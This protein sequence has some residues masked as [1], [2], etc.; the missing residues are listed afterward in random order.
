MSST[1][2]PRPGRVNPSILEP[3]PR[4][5]Q[6]RVDPFAPSY[7]YPSVSSVTGSRTSRTTPTSHSSNSGG[8]D[9][10]AED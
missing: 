6:P 4:D 9:Y 10:L 8:I 1:G 3:T 7:G 5:H 2:T